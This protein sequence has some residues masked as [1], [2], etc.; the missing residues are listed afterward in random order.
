MRRGGEPHTAASFS[1]PTQG[2]AAASSEAWKG[3]RS[4]GGL[5]PGHTRPRPP[6]PPG[7]RRRRTGGRCTRPASIAVFSLLLGEGQTKAAGESR[8]VPGPSILFPAGGA[9]FPP[10]PPFCLP[11]RPYL[12]TLCGFPACSG[13]RPGLRR[14]LGLFAMADSKG[15]GKVES[16]C[17]KQKGRGRARWLRG[18]KEGEKKRAGSSPGRG[19]R[20]QSTSL[21]QSLRK[22]RK[23]EAECEA[24]WLRLEGKARPRQGPERHH[25]HPGGAPRATPTL[26]RGPG[27]SP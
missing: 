18:G 8:P 13:G 21:P 19:R 14:P 25:R 23:G 5:E 12:R 26:H 27:P 9:P 15:G 4:D 1:R 24:D 17:E 6:I 3:E 20:Q 7:D 16:E 11:P 10:R 2:L 22:M